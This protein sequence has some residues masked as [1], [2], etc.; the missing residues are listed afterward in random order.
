M[1]FYLIIIIII[2][3]FLLERTLDFLNYSNLKSELPKELKDIYDKEKY[4]K[5]QEYEKIN[6]RFGILQ[7]IFSLFLILMMLFFDGFAVVD[8]FARTFTNNSILIALIFFG[9]LMVIS[10]ILNLPFELYS[11]FVI[12]KK[13][14]FN[15]TTK[16]LFFIDKL[17]SY[18]LAIFIG[19]GLIALLIFFYEMTKENFWLYSWLAISGFSIFM[20]MF[21][22]S[23]IVPLF[24]KQ[25]PLEAGDLRNEIEDFSKKVGFKLKNI[26]VIDASKR[27]T[28]GNAYFSGLG[29]KK[30]IVLYDTLIKDLKIKELVAILSHEIG[31]YKKKHILMSI[32]ISVLETGFTFYILSLLI[33]N[34]E[35]SKA[36][37]TENHSFHLA[38]ISFGI[39][40]S[41]ISLILGLFGNIL[42]RKN[43]FQADNFA[44]ENYEALHLENALKKLS[45]Q[46]L[47]NLKPHPLYVFFHYSHPPLLERLKNLSKN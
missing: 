35:L 15:R 3:T 24:N 30:R 40:Y 10:D 9:I 14:D 13:F 1:I 26:F 11:T 8:N 5:S 2:F 39:L 34:P 22:S 42:S 7:S 4:K 41:P 19:G 45:V 33:A 28:K 36:L 16:K 31:H 12:E 20:A 37:G 47:S 44:K 46:N 29:N 17:K 21:Y 18:L 27:S 25:T 32:F 6:S 23:L 38:M 43:E